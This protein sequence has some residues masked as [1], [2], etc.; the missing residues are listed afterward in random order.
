MEKL[1]VERRLFVAG[2]K[3]SLDPFSPL[4]TDDKKVTE[5][6]LA[7]LHKTFINAV[8]KGRKDKLKSSQVFSGLVWTGR[9]ALN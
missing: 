1:G 9:K 7:D 6:L 4:T 2:Q 8:M 3:S 5:E